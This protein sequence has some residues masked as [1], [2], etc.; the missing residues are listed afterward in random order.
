MPS[1]V[2]TGPRTV[3]LY[4]SIGMGP[5][6]SIAPTVRGA[7]GQ[8]Q[9]RVARGNHVPSLAWTP[10]T[11]HAELSS[12]SDYV[13]INIFIICVVIVAAL[14]THPSK[15]PFHDHISLKTSLYFC[16]HFPEQVYN[17]IH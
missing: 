9:S 8:K 4:V 1:V 2:K 15:S 6:Y 10:L 7:I 14:L 13:G 11:V 16:T 5:W 3:P 17:N 12:K